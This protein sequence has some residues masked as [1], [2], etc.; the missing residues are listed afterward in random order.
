MS[1]T[2][3]INDLTEGKSLLEIVTGT[4]YH[5]VETRPTI[6]NAVNMYQK[7]MLLSVREKCEYSSVKTHF[8]EVEAPKPTGATV[9]Q[10]LRY[11]LQIENL[12]TDARIP[13]IIKHIDGQT[14]IYTEYVTG[15]ISKLETA[16]KTAGFSYTLFTG[17]MKD[18]EPFREGKVQVLIASRPVS[19]GVDQ[20]QYGCDRLI[21]NML[22]YTNA[23]Y[24]QTIGRLDRN[25]QKKDVDVF[26]ILASIGGF[27]YD[28]EIKW[29]T[30]QDKRTLTDC[31]VDGSLPRKD[32]ATTFALKQGAE[33][34]AREWLQRLEE[35]Q[36]S[37]VDRSNL[38]VELIPSCK[39]QLLTF[40]DFQRRRYISEFS[41]M[42][43]IFNNSRSDT[44]HHKIQQDP[45]FLVEYNDKLDAVRSQW[46]FDPVNVIAS[47]IKGLTLPARIIR[48]YVIED[49]GCGR[50]RLANLLKG[51]RMC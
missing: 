34:A 14:I 42:N 7:F 28:K 50:A 6:P 40:S 44:I 1:A 16:V 36:L 5:D 39:Q 41:R 27:P 11:P 37:I 10:L 31:V 21:W 8:L 47:K 22:P 51:N 4:E 49:F 13:E 2:P 9:K 38:D 23:L 17:E 26:V 18:L 46:D 32:S 45:Q 19:V 25:G 20:L 43:N 33:M 15:I 3:V 12:L 29:K 24:E 30:I 35:G 48:K